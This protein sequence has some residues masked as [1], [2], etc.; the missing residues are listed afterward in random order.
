MTQ[1][2]RDLSVIGALGLV[3]LES[4]PAYVEAVVVDRQGRMVMRTGDGYVRTS[5]RYDPSRSEIVPLPPGLPVDHE[6]HV[7]LLSAQDARAIV[8][9]DMPN[10]ARDAAASAALRWLAAGPTTNKK[11]M[12]ARGLAWLDDGTYAALLV[13]AETWRLLRERLAAHAT[14]QL[15]RALR[16]GDASLIADLA[17][18]LQRAA[19]GELNGMALVGAAFERVGR[20]DLRDFMR[21]A[22][23]C[24]DQEWES[25]LASAHRVG[26]DTSNVIALDAHRVR[27][28]GQAWKNAAIAA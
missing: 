10:E 21:R 22:T 3:S 12:L 15:E 14:R 24:T 26:I 16:G 17:W 6:R 2:K 25:A 27:Q 11:S 13:S 4:T 1:P 23:P 18:R 9:A 7:L 28:Q 5:D 20:S 19:R 8:D